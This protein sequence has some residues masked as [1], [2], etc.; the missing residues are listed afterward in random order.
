MAITLTSNEAAINITANVEQ[1]TVQCTININLYNRNNIPF[2]HTDQV[3]DGDWRNGADL[4]FEENTGIFDQLLAANNGNQSILRGVIAEY[5]GFTQNGQNCVWSWS[6]MDIDRLTYF[7]IFKVTFPNAS[8][9]SHVFSFADRLTMCNHVRWYFWNHQGI[10]VRNADN[11]IRRIRRLHHNGEQEVR[12]ANNIRPANHT[13]PVIRRNRETQSAYKFFGTGYPYFLQE[14]LFGAIPGTNPVVNRKLDIAY[15]GLAEIENPFY[16][17]WLARRKSIPHFPADKQ[18]L[19]PDSN[20]AGVGVVRVQF[21]NLPT[22]AYI[23]ETRGNIQNF[24]RTPRIV[25]VNSS[26]NTFVAEYFYEQ[27]IRVGVFRNNEL[28]ESQ[29]QQGSINFL[30]DGNMLRGSVKERLV[31]TVDI[32]D[33][34]LE[35]ISSVFNQ[36][37]GRYFKIMEI[38]N[39][40]VTLL[41]PGNLNLNGTFSIIPNGVNVSDLVGHYIQITQKSPLQYGI[42]FPTNLNAE[43][44]LTGIQL[45]ERDQS[46]LT[47]GVGVDIGQGK[48]RFWL[49]AYL[50]QNS[51]VWTN[52]TAQERKVTLNVE[53]PQ[54]P[55]TPGIHKRNREQAMRFYFRNRKYFDDLNMQNNLGNWVQNIRSVSEPIPGHFI[56]RSFIDHEYIGN[57]DTGTETN[58]NRVFPRMRR[59]DGLV[60]SPNSVELFSILPLVYNHPVTFDR[61]EVRRRFANAINTHDLRALRNAIRYVQTNVR[62]N[63][64]APKINTI[65]STGE[66][67][68]IPNT[69]VIIRYMF[70]ITRLQHYYE[71]VNLNNEF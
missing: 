69:T 3:N 9:N 21:N 58:N 41:R 6:D 13:N 26:N 55:D 31:Y 60:A 10:T 63:N 65:F 36:I 71:D 18:G 29:Y 48:D 66:L 22:N 53:N 38:S 35:P 15:F 33:N 5:A 17:S 28:D 37:D 23:V 52:L 1:N 43:F 67:V 32:N 62:V 54:P 30:N 4:L 11:L 19:R 70:D 50:E 20:T 39:R 7:I 56:G 25:S 42:I 27:N 57:L 34:Q 51:E 40:T 12:P 49:D 8:T 14:A 59:V 47:F 24:Y 61:A 44:A 45:S 46:G 16:S 64:S 2:T 68:T